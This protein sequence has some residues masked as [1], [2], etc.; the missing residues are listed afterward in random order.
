[1]EKPQLRGGSY[2]TAS[3]SGGQKEVSFLSLLGL[4]PE[5]G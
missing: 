5:G 2:A 1:M 3:A 4:G